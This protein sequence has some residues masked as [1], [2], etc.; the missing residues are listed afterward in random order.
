MVLTWEH[1]VCNDHIFPVLDTAEVV[2]HG[3]QDKE[4]DAGQEG[5]HTNSSPIATGIG[6]IIDDTITLWIY[7]MPCSWCYAPKDND[8]K[9]L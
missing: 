2:K 3:I 7:C 5:D 9:Y 4:D 1:N 8:W 6:I